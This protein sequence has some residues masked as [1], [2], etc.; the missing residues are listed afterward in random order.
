M[1]NVRFRT[2]NSIN[3]SSFAQPMELWPSPSLTNHSKSSNHEIAVSFRDPGSRIQNGRAGQSQ[4]ILNLRENQKRE[5]REVGDKAV[6]SVIPSCFR[7]YFRRR[8]RRLLGRKKD[9]EIEGT[10]R[11]RESLHRALGLL[12][13]AAR[14]QRTCCLLHSG[15]KARSAQRSSTFS[16]CLPVYTPSLRASLPL[17]MHP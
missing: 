5:I 2:I 17:V 1:I 10:E 13:I 3:E 7:Y 12:Q 14:V 4:P 9:K 6:V 15:F 8:R 11:E 16:A